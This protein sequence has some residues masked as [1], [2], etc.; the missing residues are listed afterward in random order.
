[1]SAS[2]DPIPDET[3]A[4]LVQQHLVG[5]TS[6]PLDRINSSSPEHA[7]LEQQQQQEQLDSHETETEGPSNTEEI[8][9]PYHLAGA[10]VTHDIYTHANHLIQQQQQLRRSKSTNDLKMKGGYMVHANQENDNTDAIDAFENLDKP[11]GFRRF[12]IH[13]QRQQQQQQQQQQLEH[14][15]ASDLLPGRTDSDGD[16][17]GGDQSSGSHSPAKAPS[18]FHELFRPSSISSQESHPYADLSDLYRPHSLTQ[19][20][21]PNWRLQQQ[22]QQQQQQQ[23]PKR[24]RH[25]LE[26]LAVASLMDHFAG[27]DLSDSDKEEEEEELEDEESRLGEATPLLSGY[28]SN[29]RR[30]QQ[31]QQRPSPPRTKTAE[32]RKLRRQLSG[33]QPSAHRT[34]ITKTVFLLFKAFIGSGILFLPKAFSNGGLAFSIAVIWLMGIISLYCFL[35][36]L[37]CKKYISGSYGDIGEAAY[38]PWMRRIVLF[39]I[40]ISQL[41]FVCGGTIFIVQNIIEAIRGLSHNTVVLNSN[42]ILVAVCVLLM[43]FVLIR[44]IAKLS[45]T[46]LLSDVLIITG[47]VVLLVYDFIQIFVNNAS[48]ND[49]HFPSAGPNMIWVFNPTHFSVFI[50]TAVYSFEGIGLIIPIRDAMEKPEKFPMVLTGVMCMVAGTLCLV[51]TLGYVAFGSDVATVALLNLPSGTLP[52][53]IQLGYA[54]AVQLSNVLALFPTIRIVEQAFFGDRTGKYNMRIKWEKNVVRFAVVVVTGMV[55]FFGANDLDKFISLIGSICCCPL[56]LIF[57]PLFH[58]QLPST[59]GIKRWI[60]AGLILFGVGIMLFTLYNTSMQW[61]SAM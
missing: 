32:R 55:A 14:G 24:T 37:D 59:T 10:A 2:N 20:M 39:S 61:G 53:T 18:A 7:S 1:M 31:Q 58:L 9:V 23:P 54:V 21:T 6:Q 3:I 34:N 43:P 50:G 17:G 11:G 25:F 5:S 40:A 49:T 13:Q 28:P 38:G 8:P 35:L 4:D 46:A 30:R 26:Y 27:E 48:A 19:S 41:G 12:H 16:G 52:N 29:A 51:G 47:L 44:N 15:G 56:S 57:P 36:L 22:Q 42:Y 45:P 60:D 33:M